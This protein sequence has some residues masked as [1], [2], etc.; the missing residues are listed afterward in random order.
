VVLTYGAKAVV[1][2]LDDDRAKEYP[3]MLQYTGMWPRPDEVQVRRKTISFTGK[4]V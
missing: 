3:D 1:C 2:Y 4:I